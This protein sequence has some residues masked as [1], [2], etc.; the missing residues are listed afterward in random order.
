MGYRLCQNYIVNRWMVNTSTYSL[1]GDESLKQRLFRGDEYELRRRLSE[2]AS[3]LRRR[4]GETASVVRLRIAMNGGDESF[5]GDESTLLTHSLF[6][7]AHMLALLLSKSHFFL[8][9][10]LYGT[11]FPM[12]LYMQIPYIDLNYSQHHCFCRSSTCIIST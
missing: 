6:F 5:R 9:Q 10:S 11:I 2:A 7:I 3:V 4:I 12:K 8:V 1:Q